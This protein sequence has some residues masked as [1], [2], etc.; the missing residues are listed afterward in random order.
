MLTTKLT[1]AE[2]LMARPD[3][4][5]RYELIQGVPREMPMGGFG[6]GVVGVRFVTRVDRY[7]EE[8]GLGLVVGPDTGFRFERAPDQLLIPAGA[9]VRSDRLPPPERWHLVVDLVPDLVI[10]VVSPNDTGPEVAEKV[11][12]YL[13]QGV[14]LVWVAYPRRRQIVVHRSGQDAKPLAADDF[15]DGEDVLPGF[16]L[17]VGELFP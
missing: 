6:H 12:Y 10:E 16:R 17:P 11:A 14:T 2:E 4:G 9:F 5:R 1:T 15:L 3:D 7:V 8:H 13:S